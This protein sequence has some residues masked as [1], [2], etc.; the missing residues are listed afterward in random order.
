MNET[1]ELQQQTETKTDVPQTDS[2]RQIIVAGGGI[3]GLAA[4]LALSQHG[5]KVEQFEKVDGFH[6][7]GCRNSA[8]S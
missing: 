5:W 4:A 6:E 1:T 2:T 3:G 8:F 7:L